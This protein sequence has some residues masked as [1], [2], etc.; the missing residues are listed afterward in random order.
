MTTSPYSYER[1]ND[2]SPTISGDSSSGALTRQALLGAARSVFAAH[3]FEGASVRAITTEAGANLGSITYH[4]GSKRALYDAML[5]E[6]LRPILAGVQA[7]AAAEGT[8]LDR[9]IG[10]VEAYFEHLATHQDLPHLLLQEITAGKA[11]P[12]A[13]LEIIA[14]AKDTI[15]GLQIEGEAEG[16]IRAAH[17]L[18]TALSTV[19]QPIYM[20]L[21]A[22]LVRSVTGMDLSEA[23]TRR[24]VIDHATTFVRHA[25]QPVP[26]TGR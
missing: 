24:V 7:A 20:T 26:E 17:P 15:A 3:G 13:V 23:D 22:P 21:V 5:E 11:P 14:E 16:S 2:S 10:V 4:F 12:P 18:L 1:M 8:A 19:A 9:I 6:S 25:L